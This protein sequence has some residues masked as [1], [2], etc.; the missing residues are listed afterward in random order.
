MAS[1]TSALA[2]GSRMTLGGGAREKTVTSTPR[3]T[4]SPT[5]RTM[6][7]SFGS[8]NWPVTST[9]A[10]GP[11][12]EAGAA[13]GAPL[14]SPRPEAPRCRSSAPRPPS[15]VG[16][17]AASRMPPGAWPSAPAAV[18]ATQGP[19]S[20]ARHRPPPASAWRAGVRV[21]RRGGL[22]EDEL[23]AAQRLEVRV[24]GD[25]LPDQRLHLV[26]RPRDLLRGQGRDGAFHLL[27]QRQQP[28]DVADAVLGEPAHEF[29][30]VAHE[31]ICIP[32]DIGG[33]AVSLGLPR[34]GAG[35]PP[36][37]P[38]ASEVYIQRSP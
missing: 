31:L 38:G 25:Q 36:L 26:A 16:F 1:G 29:A 3:R 10:P 17:E 27:I 5:S 30:V 19:C 18:A 20:A 33:H 24:H 12:A 11:A 7:V 28:G 8:G 13:R 6:N 32:A 34:P 9:S 15:W 21:A 23:Q 22:R 35:L 4:S 14:T 2:S 37:T